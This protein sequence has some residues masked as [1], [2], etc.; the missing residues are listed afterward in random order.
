MKEAGI[1]LTSGNTRR[2]DR[3]IFRD[4]KTTI[5]DF[6]FGEGTKPIILNRLI[7]TVDCLPIWV[8]KTLRHSFG[9]STKIKL[10]QSRCQRKRIKT[11]Y[12][13]GDMNAGS[14]PTQIISGTSMAQG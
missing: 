4:G 10:Y 7:F 1:L 5:I 2:P 9:M 12:I 8:T 13:R 11:E 14:M 3:V 6:K